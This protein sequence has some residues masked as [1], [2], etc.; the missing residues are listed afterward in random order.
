MKSFHNFHDSSNIIRLIKSRRWLR[1]VCSTHG[2]DKCIQDLGRK[3]WR[4]GT[5]RKTSA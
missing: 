4:Y 2:W 3:T 1:G 5:T